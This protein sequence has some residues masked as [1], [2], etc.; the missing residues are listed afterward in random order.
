MV[1][2]DEFPACPV[3]M[4]LKLV[5]NKWKILIMRDLLA[6]GTMRFGQLKKSIG[7]ITQKVLTSNLRD[8]EEAGLLTRRVYAE[9]PPRVEYSLTEVGFSLSPVLDSMN[10][11]GSAYKENYC[12]AK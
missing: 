7:N 5:G 1:F 8:M 6:H 2:I 12:P 4:T 10:D 9:V 3:E 11:W